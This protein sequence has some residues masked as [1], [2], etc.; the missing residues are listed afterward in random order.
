MR[1]YVEHNLVA[2][3]IRCAELSCVSEQQPEILERSSSP[4]PQINSK[5]FQIVPG[6][7]NTGK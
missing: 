5:N 1:T 6:S 4:C 7:L 3:S 2:V